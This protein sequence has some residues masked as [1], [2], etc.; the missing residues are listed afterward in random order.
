MPSIGCAI[1]M[2]GDSSP[3]QTIQRLGRVLRK[4]LHES[5]LFQIYCKNTIEEEYANNRSKLFKQLAT[6]YNDYTYEIG[7]ELIL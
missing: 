7:K 1:I 4:K 3:K 5:I 2:A 6:N